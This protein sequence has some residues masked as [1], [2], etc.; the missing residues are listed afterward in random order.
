ML[1]SARDRSASGSSGPPKSVVYAAARATVAAVA[2]AMAPRRP[3]GLDIATRGV[4]LEQLRRAGRRRQ[5]DE[6]AVR[7]ADVGHVLAPR[8]RLR[9]R[10]RH[11]PLGDGAVEGALDVVRHEADLEGRGC[12]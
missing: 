8:L 6:V 7:V 2:M 9:S 4:I 5:L 10:H 3:T 11:G 1:L 12:A